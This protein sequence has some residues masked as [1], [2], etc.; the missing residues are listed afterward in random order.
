MPY[1]HSSAATNNMSTKIFIIDHFLLYALWLTD[2]LFGA[3]LSGVTWAFMLIRWSRPIHTNHLHTAVKIIWFLT[4]GLIHSAKNKFVMLLCVGYQMHLQKMR[5]AYALGGKWELQGLKHNE[6]IIVQW[7]SSKWG[8]N[9]ITAVSLGGL[10]L[11]ITV[12]SEHLVSKEEGNC[13]T[14]WD[15]VTFSRTLY[16]RISWNY[17]HTIL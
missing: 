6:K 4:F 11:V 5:N 10:T 8:G 14:N 2:I 12:R 3:P 1:K 7:V 9:W 16:H 15:S 17:C 13:I